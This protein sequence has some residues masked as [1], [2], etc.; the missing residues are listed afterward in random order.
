MIKIEE[1]YFRLLMTMCKPYKNF[2]I[3]DLDKFGRQTTRKIE[4]IYSILSNNK[5]LIMGDD[6]P[7]IMHFDIHFDMIMEDRMSGKIARVVIQKF[8]K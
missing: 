6:R 3:V 8:N 5:C 2:E 1:D 4:E 7:K